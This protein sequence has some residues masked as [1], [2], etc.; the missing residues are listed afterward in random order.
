MRSLAQQQG[1][2][3]WVSLVPALNDPKDLFSLIRPNA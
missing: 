3:S 2:G 1:L